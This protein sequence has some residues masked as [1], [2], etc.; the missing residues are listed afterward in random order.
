MR[1]IVCFLLFVVLFFVVFLFCVS[2]GAECEASAEIAVSAESAD[3]SETAGS[4]EAFPI[5]SYLANGKSYQYVCF[6]AYYQDIDDTGLDAKKNSWRW[7]RNSLVHTAL[8]KE[9]EKTP[10]LWRVLDVSE[11]NVAL[12]CSEFILFARTLN[13]NITQ[14]KAIGQDFFQTELGKYLNDVFCKDAFTYSER[15]GILPADGAG[16]GQKITIPSA[17]DLYNKD[18]GF[19]SDKARKAWGTEYA[20]RR[21]GLFVYRVSEGQHSPYWTTSQSP[22]DPRHARTTKQSGSVGHLACSASNLGARPLIRLDLNC[23]EI[24]SGSGTFDDPF[25]L[26]AIP[27]MP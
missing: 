20:I 19:G 11:D 4:A 1:K 17:N 23:I 13:S 6:G 24:E 9:L 7:S 18:Y 2:E 21:T 15:A 26:T 12:L 3:E 22:K 16:D 8:G 25:M 14:Y 5:R 27:L 10:I